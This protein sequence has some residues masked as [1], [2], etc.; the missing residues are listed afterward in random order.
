MFVTFDTSQLLILELKSVSENKLWKFVIFETFQ[1]FI[2]PYVSKALELS[3][4]HKSIA[5]S[6][7]AFVVGLNP[8]HVKLLLDL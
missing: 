1:L 5:S 3:D 4:I 2:S 6:S 8:S 7:A